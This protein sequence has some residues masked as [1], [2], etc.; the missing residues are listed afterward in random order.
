MAL[1]SYVKSLNISLYT[2]TPRVNDSIIYKSQSR[3]HLYKIK[4]QILN[5][6]CK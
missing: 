4:E 6:L 1:I 2:R 5:P 3:L